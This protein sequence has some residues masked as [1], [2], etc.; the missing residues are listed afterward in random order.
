MAHDVGS[1]IHPKKDEITSEEEH[2]KTGRRED[3]R[4]GVQ[5]RERDGP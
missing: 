3:V 5:Q 1:G 4:G 2:E